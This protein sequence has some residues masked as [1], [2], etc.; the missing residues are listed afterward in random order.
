MKILTSNPIRFQGRNKFGETR[1]NVSGTDTSAIISAF[2]KWFNKKD[3]TPTNRLREDGVWDEATNQANSKYEAEYKNFLIALMNVGL[4][5]AGIKTIPAKQVV[6]SNSTSTALPTS[7]ATTTS[8]T[9]QVSD[10]DKKLEDEKKKKKMKNIIIISAGV[11]VLGVV[12]YLI[13][14][15][16]SNSKTK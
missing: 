7:T 3:T 5:T 12:I 13:L 6:T 16:K 8:T 10:A 9:T 11:V 1:S 4:G 2:Q 15:S 14:K